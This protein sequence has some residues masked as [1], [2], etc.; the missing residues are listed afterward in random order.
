[1]EA[2]EIESKIAKEYQ[3]E[4]D[5]RKKIIDDKTAKK[6]EKRKKRKMNQ[7]KKKKVNREEEAEASPSENEQ[8]ANHDE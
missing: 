7:S 8:D 1:M 5:A 3:D 4:L 6:K 2:Q